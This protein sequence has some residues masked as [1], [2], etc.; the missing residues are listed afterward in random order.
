MAEQVPLPHEDSSQSGRPPGFEDDEL[1]P[2]D[3]GVSSGAKDPW[4]RSDPWS[5]S[6]GRGT[7]QLDRRMEEEFIQFVQWRNMQNEATEGGLR[8]NLY[9][10]VAGGGAAWYAARDEHERT[11]AGPP[12]E[13]DGSSIEFRDYKLKAKIWLRTT[14]TPAYARGPLLLKN[15]TKGPWEDLKF[16]ASDESWLNDTKNGE[17]LIA[18]MDSKEFYGEEQRES[19]LAAC[20]RLTFHLKRTKGETARSFMTRWDNAERKVREHEVKLPA[21]FLGFLMV[22]ALQLDSEK[23]K[24]L[25]NYT[26]GSLK[27]SDVK[28][29]LRIHETDLDLA[30]L[31][32]D[33]KKNAINY[34]TAEHGR[35]TQYD[36]VPDET[37]E[38]DELEE[39][40]EVMLATLAELDDPEA[41][42]EEPS[43]ILTEAETKEIMLTMVRD[44]KGR[45]KGR[46][47]SGALKAKKNRD[48]ARGYGAGR[49]GA[50]RPG[51]Y[52]V[53]I[54][55]LKKRT[56][57]NRCGAVG[58]WA[59]ECSMPKATSTASSSSRSSTTTAKEMNYLQMESIPE[60]EFYYLEADEEFSRPTVG[61]LVDPLA[62]N[63]DDESVSNSDLLFRGVYKERPRIFPCYHLIYQEDTGCATIDTG[64]QRMAIGL[65]TLQKLQR[66]Q[67]SELPIIFR[68]E[69]H[70]FR[71][72]HKVSCTERLACIPCSLGPRGCVLRPAVFEEEHSSEAPF[73]LSLPFLLHCEAT[74]ILDENKGLTLVSKQ[75]DFKVACHLGPSGAL[76]VPIQQFT[77]LMMRHLVDQ[78]GSNTDEYEVLQTE[79][80]GT[81]NVSAGEPISASRDYTRLSDRCS[82]PGTSSIRDPSSHG[83]RRAFYEARPQR[84]DLESSDP[85]GLGADGHQGSDHHWSGNRTPSTGTPQD[86]K[87]SWCYG[88]ADSGD[89]CL[90]G[91]RSAGS[92]GGADGRTTSGTSST[93]CYS[94][95]VGM[96]QGVFSNSK[97]ERE[98]NTPDSTKTFE[99]NSSDTGISPAIDVG[100]TTYGGGQQG[101]DLSVRRSGHDLHLQDSS[102]SRSSLLEVPKGPW[103]AMQ[104]L[105]MVGGPILSDSRC[106]TTEHG[107]HPEEDARRM[108][109]P[110]HDPSRVQCILRPDDVQGLRKITSQGEEEPTTKGSSTGKDTYH[111]SLQL[112]TVSD[113][114]GQCKHQGGRGVAGVSTVER[115]GGAE[116]ES[117][118][119]QPSSATEAESRGAF[120]VK[121]LRP[122][123]RRHI[124]GCLK[125]SEACW[126]DI[127][128]LLC[129]TPETDQ[130]QHLETTCKVISRSLQLQQPAMKHFTELYLLQPKQLKTVAEVCNPGRFA[131]ATDVF[132]LKAG[133]SFD[134]ELGWDLLK[135]LQQKAVKDYIRTERPGLTVIS[136]PCT[137][138]S[139][140]QNLNW[141]RW[142][143]EPKQFDI[144][145]REL[146]RARQLLK[147]CAEICQLCMELQLSF[148]F[149]HPWSASSWQEPCLQ[150]L[151]KQP[152]CHLARADQCMFGLVDQ[153]GDFMR[154]RSGFLTNNL[155]IAK[156]LNLT[157]DET[158]DHRHVMGRARGASMN[159]SRLAQKYPR[160]LVLTILGAYAISVGLSGSRIYVL[161]AN[162]IIQNEATY[163]AHFVQELLEL[164]PE[165]A[166]HAN[167]EVEEDSTDTEPH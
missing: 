106:P 66:T 48:L 144:H 9:G 160:A 96:V 138:F 111:A 153:S 136:P 25:L 8:G 17:K 58:H 110:H 74:L 6:R 20:S 26:K 119:I 62:S 63:S 135:P 109:T 41:S 103:Q 54:S 19:M 28:E 93:R 59:R 94:S 16:L 102:Q 43:V 141:L 129:N 112:T 40:T 44:S 124:Y 12:P 47:F 79:Q 33:K 164:Q 157:C 7:R 35:E 118:S 163:E 68:N 15:L 49:D 53:S 146:R 165:H 101:A 125:R 158:H 92:A 5:A 56:K 90:D 71:S 29:W 64:C 32:S 142:I 80:I 73:L 61:R 11:T 155:E 89:G 159:R 91:D 1:N 154:K 14:R 130:D 13:W 42:G 39:P 78:L 113:I 132:G 70:Q 76:R 31:G 10:G 72:V 148:V 97:E 98:R 149:E 60:S 127:H 122:G 137:L 4:G 114:G 21:D 30:N 50:L 24:L 100:G 128:N 65:V 55:E 108:P 99:R 77:T 161:D 57:C 147:F 38:I 82:N 81:A 115:A 86:A 95:G 126:L 140:L 104:L 2:S 46:T 51:T 67:P 18:L 139:M 152:Q 133:Q 75:F 107:V 156:A 131:S 27:V 105:P 120:H 37:Y 123:L 85:A 83:D 87:T 34:V 45:G 150:R 121:D 88:S 116:P 36:D 166:L 162:D 167:E 52:Q 3:D 69:K 22:N 151:I 145:I 134:L 117:G 143:D 23:T 84:T